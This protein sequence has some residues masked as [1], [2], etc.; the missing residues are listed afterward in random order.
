MDFHLLRNQIEEGLASDK[1][2][3]LFHELRVPLSRQDC[4]AERR[5]VYILLNAVWQSVSE[6]DKQGRDM[7]LLWSATGECIL[8]YK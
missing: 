3:T 8:A 7:L 1:N 2:A 4:S 6:L 5:R